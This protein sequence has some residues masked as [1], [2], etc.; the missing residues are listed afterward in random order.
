M[1]IARGRTIWIKIWVRG[2]AAGER[3]VS[4]STLAE[5]ESAR[6]AAATSAGR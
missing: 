5:S 3:I 2:Q 6:G 4:K 1:H